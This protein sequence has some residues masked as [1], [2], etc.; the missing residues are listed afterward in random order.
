M[1]NDLIMSNNATSVVNKTKQNNKT[2]S[3][4]SKPIN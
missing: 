1:S 4:K 2:V 3:K